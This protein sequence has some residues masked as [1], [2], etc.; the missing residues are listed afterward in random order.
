M[1]G[2]DKSAL[3]SLKRIAIFWFIFDYHSACSES[4]LI[5]LSH[6]TIIH[7]LENYYETVFAQSTFNCA[8]I[9]YMLNIDV[10]RDRILVQVVHNVRS[11]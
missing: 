11:G 2:D 5:Y 8:Y 7:I 1:S 6:I 4:Y 9:L 10:F 3:I